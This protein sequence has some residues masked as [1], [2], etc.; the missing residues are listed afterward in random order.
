VPPTAS[1]PSPSSPAASPWIARP[2]VDLLVGCGGWSLPLLA[3][4]YLLTG[5]SA[6]DWA[7]GF[8][9]LALRPRWRSARA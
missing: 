5:D 2:W 1:N 3:V 8:Y 7:G 6:R 9:A 4:L